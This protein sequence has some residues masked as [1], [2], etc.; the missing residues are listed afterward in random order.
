MI[1][2]NLLCIEPLS[3]DTGIGVVGPLPGMRDRCCSVGCGSVGLEGHPLPKVKC[4]CVAPRTA[5]DW[6]LRMVV[7]GIMEGY[8]GRLFGR[9][10]L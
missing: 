4:V 5:V 8:R 3:Y 10:G 1:H 6:D 9:G 2:I 7:V